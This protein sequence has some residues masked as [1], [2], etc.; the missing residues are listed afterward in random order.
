MSQVTHP[1]ITAAPH[2]R[3]MR[4]VLIACLVGLVAVGAAVLVL[5]LVDDS[6]SQ[7]TSHS[8]VS[9]TR[10]DSGPSESS[11]AAAVGSRPA[12]GPSETRV[13]ASLRGGRVQIA[14]GPDE[15]RTASA[16]AG[17]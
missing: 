17:G 13:A 6:G 11:V 8:N 16:V 5:A 2:E 14:A 4:N 1:A 15:S 9:A 12:A 3:A 10:P 7:S